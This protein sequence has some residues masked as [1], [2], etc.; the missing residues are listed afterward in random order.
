MRRLLLLVLLLL[1]YPRPRSP[2]WRRRRR[3]R[4]AARARTASRRPA[5]RVRCSRRRSRGPRLFTATRE[6][7]KAAATPMFSGPDVSECAAA[8]TAA[9]GAGVIACCQY[10]YGPAAAVRDPGGAWSEPSELTDDDGGDVNALATAVSERGD[11]IVLFTRARGS[12]LRLSAVRRTPGGDVRRA[13]GRRRALPR[14]RPTRP[15]PAWSR[16]RRP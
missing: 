15:S 8:S 5:R 7:F 11:A 1:P 4:S 6:G 3:S 9:S 12:E 10:G 14:S 16:S 13:R 2:P